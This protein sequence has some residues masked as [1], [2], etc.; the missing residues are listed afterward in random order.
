MNQMQDQISNKIRWSFEQNVAAG[1]S[2][3]SDALRVVEQ[4][5][6]QPHMDQFR[7]SYEEELEVEKERELSRSE[8]KLEAK[9]FANVDP[10]DDGYRSDNS[11]TWDHPDYV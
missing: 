1:A 7:L 6:Q 10:Y 5:Q 8:A 3:S 4:Q 9:K 2:T 11:Q